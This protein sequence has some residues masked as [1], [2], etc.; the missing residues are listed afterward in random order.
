MG[1][2]AWQLLTKVNA[3]QSRARA[4]IR[5]FDTFRRRPRFF[6]QPRLGEGRWFFGHGGDSWELEG[7]PP[8]F[9][10]TPAAAEAAA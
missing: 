4:L 5:P 8:C 2:P 10:F 7:T 6:M 9:F 3:V 1:T